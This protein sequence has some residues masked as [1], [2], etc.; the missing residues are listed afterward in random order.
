MDQHGYLVCLPAPRLLYAR[1]Y[2]GPEEET[3]FHGGREGL[4]IKAGE[5]AEF[6]V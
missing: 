4:F 1:A 2:Y 5:G 6:G 3:A